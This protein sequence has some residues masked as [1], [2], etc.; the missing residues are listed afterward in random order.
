M[1][2]PS[3]HGIKYFFSLQNPKNFKK[4]TFIDPRKKRIFV[5]EEIKNPL[6]MTMSSWHNDMNSYNGSEPR[7]PFPKFINLTK[8][9]KPTQQIVE[10]S[11][12]HAL[13]RSAFNTQELERPKSPWNV[14]KSQW[15]GYKFDTEEL[16]A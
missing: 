9:I 8:A 2:P 1:V 4:E 5:E 12:L 13:P 14:Q 7:L 15:A 10:R 11:K 16:L 6:S 3:P